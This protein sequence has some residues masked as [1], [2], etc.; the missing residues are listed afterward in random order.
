MVKIFDAERLELNRSACE[1]MGEMLW[2]AYAVDRGDRST[3][4]ISVPPQS[5]K[6]SQH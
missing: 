2:M 6:A 5:L 4:P 1:Y 3:L